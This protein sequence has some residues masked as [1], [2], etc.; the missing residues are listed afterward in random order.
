M[1]FHRAMVNFPKRAIASLPKNFAMTLRV[2]HRR[3]TFVVVV[4]P[5]EDRRHRKTSGAATSTEDH[6][7]KIFVEANLVENSHRKSTLEVNSTKEHHHRHQYQYNLFLQHLL[8]MIPEDHLYKLSV[9]SILIED[10]PCKTFVAVSPPED[11]PNPKEVLSMVPLLVPRELATFHRNQKVW[12]GTLLGR[13]VEV[14]CP[15]LVEVGCLPPS[16]C[17]A[18]SPTRSN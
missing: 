9:A 5:V 2:H 7:R 14:V 15:L 11:H 3:Q 17:V 1:D 12:Y 8:P 16:T 6:H 4:N 10:Y 18:F 13:E